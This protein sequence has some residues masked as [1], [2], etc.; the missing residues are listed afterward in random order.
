MEE[1]TNLSE[2]EQII[3]AVKALGLSEIVPEVYHDMLQPAVRQVGNGLLTVA[4]AVC[5]SLAPLELSVWGYGQIK[6]WL[7]IRVTSILADRKIEKIQL[8]KLSIAGPLVAQ[9]IFAKDELG[10]KEMY[11]SLLASSMD[12]NND[13]AHPSFVSIIQQL[14]SDE[15]K[16]LNYIAHLSEKEQ[17]LSE[18]NS[19]LGYV[20]HSVIKQFRDWCSKANIDNVSNSNTYMD[21]FIRLRIF[22]QVNGNISKALPSLINTIAGDLGG[23]SNS[24]YMY[25]ELTN[26]GKQFLDT[27]VEK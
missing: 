9:M 7:S 2:D 26:Y 14:T 23:I 20:K 17:H 11:A 16:I 8:A 19:A 21:N 22:N 4:K 5:L 13:S 24:E 18:D 3:V 6:E 12:S 27:C 10:I 1:Y 15:A 25:I